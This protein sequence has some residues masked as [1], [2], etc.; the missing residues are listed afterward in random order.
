MRRYFF[1]LHV[2]DIHMRHGD[3]S[4]RWDQRLVLHSLLQDAREHVSRGLLK[5]NALFVTA[6]S[7]SAAR[8]SKR[9]NTMPP[10]PTYRI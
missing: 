10:I 4:H 8:I 2:S 3:A 5:P 1:W 7:H 9:T 6:T